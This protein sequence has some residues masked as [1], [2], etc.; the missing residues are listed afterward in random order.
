MVPQTWKDSWLGSQEYL[1][2]SE[3]TGV[4]IPAP[5]SNPVSPQMP[6]SPASPGSVEKGSQGLVDLSA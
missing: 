2:C 1:L 6:V 4:Q 5:H 3:E